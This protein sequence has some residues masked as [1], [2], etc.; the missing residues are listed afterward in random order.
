LTNW[1]RIWRIVRLFFI[2]LLKP[3]SLLATIEASIEPET[4]FP[5]YWWSVDPDQLP[6]MPKATM[7]GVYFSS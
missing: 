6:L 2:A 4:L 7:D 3:K 5:V 1:V